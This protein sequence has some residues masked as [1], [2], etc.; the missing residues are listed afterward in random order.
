MDGHGDSTRDPAPKDYKSRP[1]ALAWFFRKSRD[2][3]K[4]KYRDLKGT[5]KGLKNR[6][7]D[8][9]RSRQRWRAK[10]ERAGERL[11]ALEA[12]NAALRARIAA[13]GGE[14]NRPR[15]RPAVPHRGT[16]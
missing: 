13:A 5:V 11:D 10:A 3:W 4:R 16:T 8:L 12:E 6:V 15:L 9:T 1:G 14:K 2:G 7:A